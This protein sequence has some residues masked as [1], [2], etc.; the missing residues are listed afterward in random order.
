MNTEALKAELTNRLTVIYTEGGSYVLAKANGAEKKTRKALEAGGMSRN[1][2]NA[3]LRE[4]IIA[5]RTTLNVGPRG[6]PNH[7]PHY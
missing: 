3:L 4:W 7:A 1:E 6:E 5:V 2:A